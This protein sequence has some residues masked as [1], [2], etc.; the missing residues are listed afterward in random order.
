MRQLTARARFVL[1]WIAILTLATLRAHP[2][3]QDAMNFT[4]EGKITQHSGNKLTL[5]TEA[6]MIFRVVYNE[7]TKI[8]GKDGGEATPKA[9]TPGTRIHVSGDLTESG[10]IIAQKITIQSEPGAGKR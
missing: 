1:L 8:A 6:N 9:L 5:N 2:L 4:V 3:G 7:K 10:E